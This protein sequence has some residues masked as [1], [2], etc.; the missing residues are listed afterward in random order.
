MKKGSK[1]NTNIAVREENLETFETYALWKSLPISVISQVP[2][3]ELSSKFG[4]D[5]DRVLDLAEIRTQLAFADKYGINKATLVAWNKK[6]LERDPLIE[7]KNWAVNLTKNVVLSLYHH[8][9]RKGN[10]HLYKLFFQIVNDWEEKSRIKLP[11]GTVTFVFDRVDMAKIRAKQ[12][13]LRKPKNATNTE[14]TG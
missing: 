5:D 11:P 1:S 2:R 8:A 14:T 10:A 12:E 4:I 13:E 6:I 3:D 9:I 7:A